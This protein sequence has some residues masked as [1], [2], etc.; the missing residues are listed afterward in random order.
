MNCN[1]STIS[2]YN[3]VI[4]NFNPIEAPELRQQVPQMFITEKPSLDTN[5][6]ELNENVYKKMTPHR[7]YKTL[8]QINCS[9]TR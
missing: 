5:N 9:N 4:D 8:K 7:P 2:N 1:Y 3:N 6:Y